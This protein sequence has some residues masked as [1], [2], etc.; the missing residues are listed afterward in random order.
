MTTDGGAFRFRRHFAV[1]ICLTALLTVANRWL[2]VHGPVARFG[3]YGALYSLSLAVAVRAAESVWRRLQFVALGALLSVSNVTVGIDASHIQ[4]ALPW[5]VG[6]SLILVIC[7]GLGAASYA[8]LVRIVWKAALS[9][10]A[11]VS[12]TLCC[13]L[14]ALGVLALHLALRADGLWVAVSWWFAFSLGLWYRD[15][16]KRSATVAGT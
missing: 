2:P 15:G 10:P 3:M 16:S 7:A 12:M 1:L 9:P 6:P 4:S 11:V 13:M 8:V 5:A 14:A